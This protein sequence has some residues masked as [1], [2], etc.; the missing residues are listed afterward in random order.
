MPLP[1][2][3]DWAYAAGFVDGEGCIVVVR[4][5]VTSTAGH[6][7]RV[8]V[9]VANRDRAVLEW[10]RSLWGGWVVGKLPRTPGAQPIWIWRSPTGVEAKPFLVGIRPWLRIKSKQCDNAVT[11]IA[12]LQERRRTHGRVVQLGAWNS[13]L[14][15]LY[16][17][18]RRLN[19]RGRA[20][21][22]GQPRH[23]FDPAA[24]RG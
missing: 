14:E 22:V 7:Y 3:T 18:Q 9:D 15:T 13:R 10:M 6:Q 17:I 23:P 21:F 4:S 1:I 19:H 12:L 11:M 24:M 2:D 16:W 5:S 20:E 8:F